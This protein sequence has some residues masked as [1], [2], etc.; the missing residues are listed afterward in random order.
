[1]LSRFFKIV[2][3]ERGK[4]TRI[5]ALLVESYQTVQCMWNG[6]PRMS[7]EYWAEKNT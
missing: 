5:R 7:G 1:M 2:K 4:Q 3:L 6:G